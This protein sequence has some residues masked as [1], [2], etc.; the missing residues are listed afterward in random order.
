LAKHR[1]V[2][3]KEF[4]EQAPSYLGK[5]LGVRWVRSDSWEEEIRCHMLAIE[6]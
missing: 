5:G 3:S 2:F 1:R 4:K 6:R